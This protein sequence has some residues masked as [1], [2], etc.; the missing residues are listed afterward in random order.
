MHPTMQLLGSVLTSDKGIY[1]KGVSIEQHY[2]I[3]SEKKT[4]CP[5]MF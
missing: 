3:I 1:C 2:T 4:R 5:E